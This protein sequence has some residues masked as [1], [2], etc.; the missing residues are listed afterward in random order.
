MTEFEALRDVSFDVAPG[1][2][3]GIV[4]RNGSGKSTLLKIIAGI[5]RADEGKVAVNG[6][7][8]SFIEL[9]VGFNPELSGYD[10]LVING[11]LLGLSR[12]EVMRRLDSIVDFAEL[13]GFMDMKL[14]N[15]S[16]GM[17]VRLAFS[18]A[19]Q[20]EAE[21]LLTDEVL[22]VG[23]ARFQAK[24]FE[25][26]RER[27]RR[28]QTLV[29]VSHDMSAINEFCDRVLVLDS[30]IPQGI[31]ETRT[32]SRRYFQINET[33]RELPRIA[34]VKKVADEAPVADDLP[35]VE[36]KPRVEI[37]GAWIETEPG[38]AATSV[39]EDESIGCSVRLRSDDFVEAPV[40][41]ISVQDSTGDDV[42]DES[43]GLEPFQLHAMQVGE[44]RI[45]EIRFTNPLPPGR[46]TVSCAVS[47]R[48][49]DPIPPH[50]AFASFEVLSSS[51]PAPQP[52]VDDVEYSELVVHMPEKELA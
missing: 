33:D 15:Y 7:L 50:R 38:S 48:L 16:S 43:L 19:L 6:S 40:L 8:A 31:G 44:E 26:F 37:L 5:Y 17:Q 45:A 12:R 30:G 2:F 23:D 35:V 13:D 25:V 32:M 11:S 27:K 49:V 10:N 22:A 28:G 52:R 20:S 46:Y 51:P 21:I 42:L 9:G 41:G 1:E 34:D 18:I 39:V 36:E 3:F 47:A 29:F 14:R 4:G 24:C